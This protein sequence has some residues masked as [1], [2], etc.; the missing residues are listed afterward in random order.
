MVPNRRRVFRSTQS[1]IEV[2]TSPV[3]RGSPFVIFASSPG[4]SFVV[5]ECH[6]DP[7]SMFLSVTCVAYIRVI[8]SEARKWALD[9]NVSP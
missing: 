9:Q 7:H 8:S 6:P 4:V 1:S 5:F 2:R 3:T